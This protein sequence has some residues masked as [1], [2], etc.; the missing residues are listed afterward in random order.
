MFRSDGY[1]NSV[2][3]IT[4]A[5]GDDGSYIM[6]EYINIARSDIQHFIH[7]VDTAH[8][9]GIYD[10]CNPVDS[11]SNACSRPASLQILDFLR[12][13]IFKVFSW[14]QGVFL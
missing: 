3:G 14:I 9:L 8:G 13:I 5:G 6:S 7:V 12:G 11:I 4:H 10:Y 2:V 1:E